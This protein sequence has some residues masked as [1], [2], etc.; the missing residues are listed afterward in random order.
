MTEAGVAESGITGG[1]S[2]ALQVVQNFLRE[3]IS[4]MRGKYFVSAKKRVARNSTNNAGDTVYV[5]TNSHGSNVAKIEI[6]IPEGLYA[7]LL[8]EKSCS[9]KEIDLLRS[10][11]VYHEEL[12]RRLIKCQQNSHMERNST[13]PYTDG[14]EGEN[15]ALTELCFEVLEVIDSLKKRIRKLEHGGYRIEVASVVAG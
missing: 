7:G 13:Q 9:K 2:G 15:E 4:L 11:L 5:L 8:G 12:L 3:S 1:F 10:K 14:D 6:E